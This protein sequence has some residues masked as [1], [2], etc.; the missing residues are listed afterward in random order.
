MSEVEVGLCII[1]PEARPDALKRAVQFLVEQE[2]VFGDDTEDTLEVLQAADSS[3]VEAVVGD[4][5]VGVGVLDCF[6]ASWGKRVPE[7]GYIAVDTKY[8]RQGIA[9]RMLGVLEGMAA[10]AGHDT[11]YHY[12]PSQ[13]EA[14]FERLG[15]KKSSVPGYTSF[16]SK[17]LNGAS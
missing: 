3:T 15:Y 17:L 16:M 11:V 7:I 14:V 12:P 1:D 4:E 10:E 8:R 6:T 13:A 9:R 2:V 5:L